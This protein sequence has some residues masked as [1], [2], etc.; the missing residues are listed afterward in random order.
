MAGDTPGASRYWA[1]FVTQRKLT[2]PA[3]LQQ[4][5]SARP[6]TPAL[7]ITVQ[8]VNFFASALTVGFW[9]DKTYNFRIRQWEEY[10]ECVSAVSSLSPLH[11]R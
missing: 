1:R 8:V 5:T 7:L 11:W 9:I 3:C 2:T 4:G 6:G 10:L